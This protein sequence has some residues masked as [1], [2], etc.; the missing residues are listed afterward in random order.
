VAKKAKASDGSYL[1]IDQERGGYYRLV[2]YFD[3]DYGM[4]C[5]ENPKLARTAPKRR[6]GQTEEDHRS[7][8]EAHAVEKAIKPLAHGRDERGFYWE[9]VV[10]AH[11]AY[12]VACSVLSGKETPWP[13]W[14]IQAKAAGWTPPKG[15]KP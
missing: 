10:A 8:L 11:R 6:R 9:S 14:A 13:Q 12:R 3:G 5:G 2:W 7:D 1:E 15:W 4:V